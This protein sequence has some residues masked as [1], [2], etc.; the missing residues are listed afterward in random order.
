MVEY[1]PQ[2]KHFTPF[3]L[4]F[5]K[6]GWARP[7]LVHLLDTALNTDMFRRPLFMKKFYIPKLSL[8]IL[9]I[10]FHF[11]LTSYHVQIGCTMCQHEDIAKSLIWLKLYHMNIWNLS[12]K[13]NN[14]FF[15]IRTRNFFPN[16][17]R[18]NL[19]LCPF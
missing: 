15:K 14:F 16:G 5:S 8:R 6:A 10:Y 7:T 4:D 2:M 12:R 13:D 19:K 9:V 3:A 18:K 1:K 11:C 17:Q